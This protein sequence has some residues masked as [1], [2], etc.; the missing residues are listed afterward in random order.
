MHSQNSSITLIAG[1]LNVYG[2]CPSLLQCRLQCSSASEFSFLGCYLFLFYLCRLSISW[3]NYDC[4][5]ERG[6]HHFPL[7]SHHHW[8]GSRL[9]SHGTWTCYGTTGIQV[10]QGPNWLELTELLCEICPINLQFLLIVFY[11]CAVSQEVKGRKMFWRSFKRI[12]VTWT[13]IFLGG[14]TFFYWWNISPHSMF[15][16]EHLARVSQLD[17]SWVAATTAAGERKVILKFDQT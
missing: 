15:S 4:Q 12:L 14:S 17:S 3:Q 10:S 6:A 7:A 11:H 8:D 9:L 5:N 16:S 2:Q 1:C 13:E